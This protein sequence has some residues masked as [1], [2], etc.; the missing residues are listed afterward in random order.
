MGWINELKEIVDLG[1][2]NKI[3]YKINQNSTIIMNELK[4][5]FSDN[6]IKIC[7][8]FKILMVRPSFE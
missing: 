8:K 2:D 5:S 7:W 3:H 1:Y 6:M 4:K